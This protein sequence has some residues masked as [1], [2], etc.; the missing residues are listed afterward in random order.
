M[1][2]ISNASTRAM[3]VDSMVRGRY[4]QL[5]QVSERGQYW[6]RRQQII[7]GDADDVCGGSEQQL[8]GP[9]Q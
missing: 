8:L 9:N 2:V 6:R 7:N 4:K 5:M 1:P 3:V